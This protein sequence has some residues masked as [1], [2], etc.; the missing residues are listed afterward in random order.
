[1]STLLKIMGIAIITCLSLLFLGHLFLEHNSAKTGLQ[2]IQKY[3]LAFTLWRYGL[4]ALVLLLWPYF[5]EKVGI[6]QKWPTQT[7]VYLSNQRLKLL[8]FFA[9]I[10]IFFVYNLLGHLLTWV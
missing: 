8:G 7:I 2:V 6:R 5:I 3:H 9:F 4:Y 1:M 10:E